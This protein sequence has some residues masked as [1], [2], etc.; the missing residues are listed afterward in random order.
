MANRARPGVATRH[1]AAGLS[2]LPNL[3]Q[4]AY[5]SIPP[6]GCPI[7]GAKHEPGRTTCKPGPQLS[8]G[9]GRYF[10]AVLSGLA[11][12]RF[13]ATVVFP[14]SKLAEPPA[15]SI[16][17]LAVALK[18]WAVILSFLVSSPSPRT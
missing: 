15:C 17:A 13:S 8:F 6:G 2:R 16:L 9:G 18:R 7:G 12:A 3:P 11:F 10:L 5:A 14:G 1:Q 4:P